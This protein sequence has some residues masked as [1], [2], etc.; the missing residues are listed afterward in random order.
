M[1]RVLTISCALGALPLVLYLARVGP[2][3]VP[4]RPGSRE[5][6]SP[7]TEPPG[8]GSAT[9]R[10]TPA[11][12]PP[13]PTPPPAAPASSPKVAS[14]S[15]RPSRAKGL[16]RPHA[17]RARAAPT[18]RRPKRTSP[19]PPRPALA[20]VVDPDGDG[21]VG[22]VNVNSAS[23]G[24]LTLLPGMGPK[25]A[26]AV[27]ALRQRRPYR[28]ARHVQRVRGIGPKTFRRWRPHLK[29]RGEST[30]RRVRPRTAR[31]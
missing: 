25:R 3:P 23:P 11:A 21:L 9:A 29:V 27:V 14:A 6:A 13:T 15:R 28:Y 30:L 19:S 18:P 24:E 8:V 12:L 22:A 16:S 2:G 4:R 7:S 5:E 26:A 10:D 17:R 1:L 31:R 20:A